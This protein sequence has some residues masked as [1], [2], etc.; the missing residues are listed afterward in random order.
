MDKMNAIKNINPFNLLLM[1]WSCHF[2]KNV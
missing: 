1:H 2:P